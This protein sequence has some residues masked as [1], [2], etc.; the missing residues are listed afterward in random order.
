MFSNKL[1]VKF[2]KCDDNAII[3]EYSKD[4]DSGFDFCCTHDVILTNKHI[5]I[6]KTG[7][8]LELPRSVEIS[9][10]PGLKLTP[11]LQI[12]PRSGLAKKYGMTIINTPATIDNGYRGEIMIIATKLTSGSIKID[13]GSRIAQGVINLVVSNDSSIIMNVDSIS[14][15]ERGSGGFGHTGL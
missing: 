10:I 14:D 11:E 13:K 6:I 1:V 5:S 8:K 2:E 12:R 9:N 15:T 3:P 7:L 4:G